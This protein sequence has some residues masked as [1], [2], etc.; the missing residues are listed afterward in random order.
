MILPA[1]DNSSFEIEPM[2]PFAQLSAVGISSSFSN[3]IAMVDC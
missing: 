3:F 1:L 2:S